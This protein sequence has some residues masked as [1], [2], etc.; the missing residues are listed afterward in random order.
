MKEIP[1]YELDKYLK[2][3]KPGQ[4]DE[5]FKKNSEYMANAKKSFSYYMKDVIEKKNINL[6][7]RKIKLKDIYLLAGVSETY[8]EK[9]MNMTS[10][11]TNRDLIIRFCIAGR[12]DISEVNTALKLYGMSPLYSKNKRDACIIVAIN[13]RKY[14]LFD[15][16][17]MLE[18]RGLEKL[19]KD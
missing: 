16:D 11:S 2:D 17:D 15:I 10:H 9:V 1:T 14:D 6:G 8:G 18:Q 19:S 4:L 13:N 12:F 3:V 7:K 5:Y